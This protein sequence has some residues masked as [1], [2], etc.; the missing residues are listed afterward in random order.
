MR[1]VSTFIPPPLLLLSFLNLSMRHSLLVLVVNI[2]S[3]LYSS[4][5]D[6]SSTTLHLI[7]HIAVGGQERS[8]SSAFNS[9]LANHSLTGGAGKGVLDIRV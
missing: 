7:S 1:H 3:S 8:A 2:A 5:R 4:A 9:S 6:N